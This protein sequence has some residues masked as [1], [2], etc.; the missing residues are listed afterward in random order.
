MTISS[1]NAR[2][3][4][5]QLTQAHHLMVEAAALLGSGPEDA[6]LWEAILI[7]LDTREVAEMLQDPAEPISSD[8]PIFWI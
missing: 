7:V 5:A 1:K 3:A 6:G 2:R 4:A 8:A